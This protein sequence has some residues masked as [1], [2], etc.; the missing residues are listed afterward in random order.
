MH[1]PSLLVLLALSLVLVACGGG[2]GGDGGP[3][4]A[5]T[6]L[7]LPSD[8]DIDG[9]VG[10]NDLFFPTSTPVAGDS[11][12]DDGYRAFFA[13]NLDSIPADAQI[14]SVKLRL[15]QSH[16]LG[17]PY[18]THG[19]LVADHI[20]ICT[21]LDLGD[22]TGS[23]LRAAFAVVSEDAAIGYREVD[24][25]ER[26]LADLAAGRGLAGF[27]IRFGSRQSD[28]DGVRDLIVLT[29]GEDS[30]GIGNPPQLIIQYTQ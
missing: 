27:R 19:P 16:V 20:D 14:V 11:N 9:W 21:G 5:L 2:G 8:G 29:D 18:S 22:Y 26:V 13:F 28:N 6:A 10:N 17:D 3:P 1:R 4:P 12:L 7:A 24:A 15:Y 30:G 25:T 23:N